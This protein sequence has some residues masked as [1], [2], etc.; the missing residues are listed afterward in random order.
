MILPETAHAHALQLCRAEDLDRQPL[1]LGDGA[2][3]IGVAR[4]RVAQVDSHALF[5]LVGDAK[6][7]VVLLRAGVDVPQAVERKLVMNARKYPEPTA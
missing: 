3:L 6:G 2:R 4:V 5:R 1:P 7:V